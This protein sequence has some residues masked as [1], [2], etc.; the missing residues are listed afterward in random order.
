MEDE[1]QAYYLSTSKLPPYDLASLVKRIPV[2]N[3]EVSWRFFMRRHL[4][5]IYASRKAEAW[6]ATRK[7][8]S[9]RQNRNMFMTSTP[10]NFPAEQ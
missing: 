9:H 7:T 3:D 5:S 6:R 8:S 4:Y 2:S 10:T 1:A